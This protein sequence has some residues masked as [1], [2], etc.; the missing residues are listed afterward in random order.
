V[1]GLFSVGGHASGDALICFDKNAFCS[2]DLEK[3]ANA[4]VSEEAVTAVN[5]ALTDL[6][7]QSA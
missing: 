4:P 5:A 2:Y 7:F 3:A 6:Y 1:P